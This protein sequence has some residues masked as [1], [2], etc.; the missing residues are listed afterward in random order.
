M[1]RL[2]YLLTLAL[3]MMSGSMIM[4]QQ[5]VDETEELSIAQIVTERASNEE[6]PQFSILLAALQA[7]SPVYLEMLTDASTNVTVFAPTDD[8]FAALLADLEM[9]AA[10]LLENT[11]LL[12]E[13]LAYHVVPGAFPAESILALE[14]ALIGTTL[15]GA[16]LT[17]S[18]MDDDTV[19]IQDA[20][21]IDVDLFASNGIIHVIDSVLVPSVEEMNDE[22][23]ANIAEEEMAPTA[24]TFTIASFVVDASQR[25]EAEFSI[26]LD[27][28]ETADQA[29]LNALDGPGPYT[30]FAPTDAA[31]IA[32]FDRLG[33]TSQE[34]LADE[35]L[36]TTVLLY[37]VV[38]G[39]FDAAA[40]STLAPPIFEMDDEN[41]DED[42]PGNPMIATLLRG[43]ALEIIPGEGTID[44]TY[45]P[46]IQADVMTANGI[47]HVI[48]DVLIPPNL[49]FEE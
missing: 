28:V 31:F 41:M 6:D 2:I 15:P 18:V 14:G 43:T 4:A 45:A 30:V 21:V 23:D 8:A 11:A 49:S 19:M 20:A 32:A 47:I 42:A 39:Q 7:S 27:A 16:T 5:D 12:D 3:F 22:D 38:P 40:L 36:V 24:G 17:P 44:I 26:L 48:E 33:V 34:F 1:R 9:E 46:V 37:H 25:E 10:A 35:E 13:V 29:V